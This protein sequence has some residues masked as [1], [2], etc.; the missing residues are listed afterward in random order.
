MSQEPS[1]LPQSTDHRSAS[2]SSSSPVPAP[3]AGPERRQTP[4]YR[5]VGL[6]E[7][8]V[9]GR[10]LRYRGRI[11]NLSAQGAFI[12]TDCPLERGTSVELRMETEGMPLRVAANLM[13][14]RRNGVGLR[15]HNVTARKLDQIHA[16]IAELRENERHNP[17]QK[18]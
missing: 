16:I 12:E 15:F 11:G 6:A 4:R 3:A 5:C 9:P 7:I 18:S 8:A 14:R 2:P 10:G 1:G 13:A 17:G